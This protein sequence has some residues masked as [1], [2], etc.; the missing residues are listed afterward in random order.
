MCADLWQY[1]VPVMV[2][3]YIAIVCL[4]AVLAG[5]ANAQLQIYNLGNGIVYRKYATADTFLERR[6]SNFNFYNFLIVSK[7]PGFPKKRI[8]IKF[9]IIGDVPSTC[10]VTFAKMY[11]NFWYA[12]KASF[13][14]VQQVPYLSRRLQVHQINKDWS[15]TQ[16]TQENRLSGTP[17]SAP[18]LAI[19]GTDASTYVQDCVPLYTGRAAGYMEFDVTVAVKSWLSG[20][21]NYG[22]L[23]WDVTENF[24]GRDIRFHS[25]ETSDTSKRPFLNV[26][27]T[28]NCSSS[29]CSQHYPP[30]PVC[31]VSSNTT[32]A[33]TQQLIPASPVVTPTKVIANQQSYPSVAVTQ[34]ITHQQSCPTVATTPVITDQQ[35]CQPVTATQVITHQQS[36]QPVTATRVITHQQSCQPVT[37]TRVITH[38]QSCQPV[39]ATQVITHQQSCPS[40]GA[41][42]NTV[43]NEGDSPYIFGVGAAVV[44]AYISLLVFSIIMCYTSYRCGKLKGWTLQGET[45]K[46]G[47]FEMTFMNNR[48]NESSKFDD[49]MY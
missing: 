15:E 40:V 45:E 11:L 18:Y 26:F 34:V 8:L 27:C 28:P 46:H 6:G 3:S 22:L 12:H 20:D 21:P 7:H 2:Q 41:I 38:Q 48:N 5:L 16:A 1:T 24:D 9:D 29:S 30:P 19:N 44:F 4:A 43:V 42:P 49:I 25:R 17:W 33:D 10:N 23:V 32:G 35:S 13:Q 37:A 47:T 31:P 14:S 39:T 36:C